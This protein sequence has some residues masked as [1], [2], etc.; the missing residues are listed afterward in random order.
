L[1]AHADIAEHRHWPFVRRAGSPRPGALTVSE[2]I[3]TGIG[4]GLLGGVLMA[5]PL[6]LWD[7]VKSA[8]LALE[9]PMAATAWIFG[10]N[11]FSHVTN[12][13]GPI[14]LGIVFFCLYWIVS[15]LA[16][17]G[18][19][20]RLYGIA[21]LGR[22]LVAGAAWGFVN[23]MFFWYMLLPIARDGAP[24]RATT[25]APEQFVAPNWVWILS[26]VVFGFATAFFYAVL[27]PQ[28]RPAAD[29]VG[30]GRG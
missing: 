7:W 18:L 14:V 2:W 1:E 19:A 11:H 29:E 24:F 3:R 13:P 16:F 26:F 9:L 12:R 17:T 23:F 5:V 21:T 15:G 30:N 4:A 6:I 8:H 10:L 27:R 20:D 28:P 22:S 25:A